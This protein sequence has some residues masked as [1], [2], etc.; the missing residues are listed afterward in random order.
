MARLKV[1]LSHL[2]LDKELAELL[3]QAISQDFIGLVD[4]FVSSD[5]T[6]IPVGEKWLDKLVSELKAADL[7][8]VLCSPE[9]VT[10]P[11]INFE[12]GAARLRGI[13]IVPVCHSGL[14][15]VQLPVPLS[16]FEAMRASSPDDLLKLYGRIASA[17][18]S[19]VP[20]SSLNDLVRKIAA[21]EVKYERRQVAEAAACEVMPATAVIESPR[22]LCVSS[23][24]FMHLGFEDFQVILK[25]FPDEKVTHQ[26]VRTSEGTRTLLM[27]DHFDIVHVATYI[28]PK[29]GDLVFS[30]VDTA[31]GARI[32]GSG[33]FLTAEA[34]AS[35]LKRTHA[36]LAVIASCESFEL[37]AAL[38]PVTN[39]VAT[40]D[41]VAAE[42]FAAWVKS[43]YEAL[44]MQPLSEAFD[45]AV[46]ASRAPMK[47]YAK[48]DIVVGSGRERA[49]SAV[50]KS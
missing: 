8:L 20:T 15:P 23:E 16:E 4:F 21:F 40:R 31:T 6:S 48:Q 43:F 27:R 7:H 44:P 47:L 3:Q 33:E 30:E 11:W 37:A 35:L 41:I 13:P 24:Q 26:Q 38:L 18:G 9:A 12:T 2:N 19:T 50:S 49:R 17:L 10:R 45:F 1:F 34:F 36:S 5:T 39:V 42:T 28:C 14:S 46:K 32:C 29:T 22:I 25:A